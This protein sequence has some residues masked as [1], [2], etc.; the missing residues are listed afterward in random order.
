MSTNVIVSDLGTEFFQRVV[1]QDNMQLWHAEA[2]AED[3]E[4]HL[5][6]KMPMHGNWARRIRQAVE[7][8]PSFRAATALLKMGS[9]IV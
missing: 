8:T 4:K 7:R 6:S 5:Q 2:Y 9:R 3:I 1:H